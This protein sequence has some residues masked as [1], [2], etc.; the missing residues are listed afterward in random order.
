MSKEDRQRKHNNKH[1]LEK[2]E[3]ERELKKND[4]FD[5]SINEINLLKLSSH[6]YNEMP[7]V[8]LNIHTK[9]SK[10]TGPR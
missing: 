6:M 5:W 8:P 2:S 9:A 7:S 3:R 4:S 1:I 10:G